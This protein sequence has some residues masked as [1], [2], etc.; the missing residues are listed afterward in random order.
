MD[1]EIMAELR[2]VKERM[3]FEAGFDVRRLAEELRL[4]QS[5]TLAE[6]W[7]YALPATERRPGPSPFHLIRFCTGE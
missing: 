5:Q 6:G 7:H 2:Q 4:L 3:A 1:D